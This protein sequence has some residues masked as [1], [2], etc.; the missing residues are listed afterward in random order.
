MATLATLYDRFM[1][2]SGGHAD[3]HAQWAEA[4]A[5]KLTDYRLRPFPNEDIAFHL[6]RIDNSRVIRQMDPQTP[7][8]C[9]NMIGVAG[10]SAVVLIGLLLPTAYRLM[11]GYQIEE[12]KKDYGQ[13]QSR[14]AEMELEE[15]R[16][17]SPER[18]AGLAKLQDF[19]DPE[20]GRVIHLDEPKNTEVALHRESRPLAVPA[21]IAD[22]AAP[23]AGQPVETQQ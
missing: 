6:K 16:L 9:W 12:L 23:A 19:V 14:K 3:V 13:L 2:K 17:L 15:A 8:V 7:R 1:G 4:R 20:P 10:A 21:R 5:Q 22:S 18:L 11:A